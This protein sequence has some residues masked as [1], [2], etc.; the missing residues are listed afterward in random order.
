[1][2]TLEEKDRIMKKTPTLKRYKFD[3]ELHH[4]I[5]APNKKEAIK[6]ARAIMRQKQKSG[7]WFSAKV[8]KSS[9]AFSNKNIKAYRSQ[10]KDLQRRK[11]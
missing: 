2:F 4:E 3:Y 10:L 5:I 7:I 6:K 11:K 8:T 9:I 1:V